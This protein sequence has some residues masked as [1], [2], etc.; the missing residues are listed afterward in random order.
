MHAYAQQ[1]IG[2][3]RDSDPW[4]TD[5]VYEATSAIPLWDWAQET[6][7]IDMLAEIAG[8]VATQY[9]F[10]RKDTTNLQATL[11][12]LA[13]HA[14]T[15]RQW[16]HYVGFLKGLRILAET[17]WQQRQAL[18]ERICLISAL[19]ADVPHH[20]WSLDQ[21][22]ATYLQRGFLFQANQVLRVA[23]AMSQ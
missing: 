4:K 15:R 1:L 8:V 13:V 22:A 2:Q 9:L 12:S 17:N 23:Y 3:I 14:R 16:K 20:I 6:A 10:F 5:Y 21:V 19:L 7:A 18:E 11:Q